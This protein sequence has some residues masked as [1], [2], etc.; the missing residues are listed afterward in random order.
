M[1]GYV[2]VMYEKGNAKHTV[3]TL[4]CAHYNFGEYKPTLLYLMK[5]IESE[6]PLLAVKEHILPYYMMF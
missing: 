1:I 2:A 6:S 5:L 4:I 3:G